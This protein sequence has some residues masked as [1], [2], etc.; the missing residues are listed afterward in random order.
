LAGREIGGPFLACRREPVRHLIN[1]LSS[2]TAPAS[3]EISRVEEAKGACGPRMASALADKRL[4][5]DEDLTHVVASQEELERRIVVEE[6]FD[7]SIVKDALK[8]ELG[9][10]L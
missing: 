9:T 2:R 6:I 3:R 7:V 10:T 4:T 5:N 8:P 1:A